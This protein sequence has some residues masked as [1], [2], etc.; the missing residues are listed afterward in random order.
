[1]S[2]KLFFIL[3]LQCV[4]IISVRAQIP[5]DTIL[6][7]R[8]SGSRPNPVYLIKDN[9]FYKW[10]FSKYSWSRQP[11]EY[12]LYKD[13]VLLS[14][15]PRLNTSTYFY[16]KQKERLYTEY[17]REH[18]IFDFK[19]DT[20]ITSFFSYDEPTNNFSIANNKLYYSEC[21]SLYIRNLED[22]KIID[23]VHISAIANKDAYCI[24]RIITFPS[25]NEILI[26]T[27]Y[28]YYG[29]EITDIQYYI[30]NEVSK[31]LN[32]AENNDVIKE[33]IEHMWLASYDVSGEYAFFDEYIMRSTRD[34]FSKKLRLS[35]GISGFV[36]S[37][38]KIKQLLK[39]SYLNPIENKE[40]GNLVLIPFVP[41]PF[42]EK[43]MY[44]IY[45]NIE[46]KAQD[47]QRFDVFDLRLLR[48]MIFAKHYYAFKDKFLQAYFNLYNFYHYKKNLLTDVNHLLTPIDKKNLELIL[49][50]SKQKEKTK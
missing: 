19:K 9:V 45:E 3:L 41:D 36:I 21:A 37:E 26:E 46:L 6:Y 33:N 42:K 12:F 8:L 29:D 23:S 43:S 13:D 49:Q 40:R 16:D 24:S 44:E 22:E 20:L 1:M 10:Q 2:K 25:T 11:D 47:L 18:Y 31:K 7:E 32:L 38:G 50:V 4:L 34:I 27:G 28:V 15:V 5:Q 30:Y 35:D 48:N 17:G 39:Y 14:T